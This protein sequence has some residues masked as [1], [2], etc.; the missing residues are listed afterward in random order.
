LAVRGTISPT[1]PARHTVAVSL[2]RTLGSTGTAFRAPREIRIPMPCFGQS[3]KQ[4][5]NA[6]SPLPYKRP[7]TAN[8]HKTRHR[9]ARTNESHCSPTLG[10]QP[11]AEALRGQQP[12]VMRRLCSVSSLNRCL[13]TEVRFTRHQQWQRSQPAPHSA[14]FQLVVQRLAWHRCSLKSNARTSCL[15]S[16]A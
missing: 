3:A 8:L 5:S 4:A 13:S 10:M 12:A 9:A 2:A 6:A 16:A 7:L 15:T 11:V 14:H 1:G